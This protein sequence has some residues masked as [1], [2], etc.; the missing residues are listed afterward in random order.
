MGLIPAKF[1]NK[2]SQANGGV[3]LIGNTDDN[4]LVGEEVV[5]FYQGHRDENKLHSL[6]ELESVQ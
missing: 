2:K 5:L 1:Q 4:I 3:P 6:K